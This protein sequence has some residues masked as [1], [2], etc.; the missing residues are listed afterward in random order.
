MTRDLRRVEEGRGLVLEAAEIATADAW[1]MRVTFVGRYRHDR[2]VDALDA[3]DTCEML[4]VCGQPRRIC[5]M[6]EFG[7]TYASIA[8]TVSGGTAAYPAVYCA[9]PAME[10][11]PKSKGRRE[12]RK[13]LSFAMFAL[14]FTCPDRG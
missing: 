6:R 3:T 13:H 9:A 7:V 10:P 2:R 8:A 4:D 11:K 1:S 12:I 5:S 14:S